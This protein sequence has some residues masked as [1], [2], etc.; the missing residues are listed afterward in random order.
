MVDLL[1]LPDALLPHLPAMV[2][3]KQ[4]I[5]LPQDTPGYLQWLRERLCP[6]RAPAAPWLPKATT[7]QQ[8]PALGRGG[9]CESFD[10]VLH[11]VATNAGKST[12]FSTLLEVG[13]TNA[14]KSTLFSTLL[15][16][17]DCIAKGTETLYRA[18]ISPWPD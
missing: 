17:E 5:V 1:H 8:G 16:S 12:L 4:L 11:V 13:A 6:R 9:E 7:P 18:T 15:E 2:G 10:Q 14:G 3:P